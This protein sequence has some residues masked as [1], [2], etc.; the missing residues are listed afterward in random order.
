MNSLP[1]TC[2]KEFSKGALYG[3]NMYSRQV[4]SIALVRQKFDRAYVQVL[5]KE[6]S[7]KTW[8]IFGGRPDL[9]G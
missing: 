6:V 8:E 3:A 4:G 9:C 1:H 2:I 7:S 5:L